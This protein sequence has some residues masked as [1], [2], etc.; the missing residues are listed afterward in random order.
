MVKAVLAAVL[1]LLQDVG[2]FSGFEQN[3]LLAICKCLEAWNW[4]NLGSNTIDAQW[5]QINCTVVADHG[6]SVPGYMPGLLYHV[7]LRRHNILG[8][9]IT[10]AD[11]MIEYLMETFTYAQENEIA[12]EN[13]KWISIM[14]WFKYAAA[15]IVLTTT[16]DQLA[17]NVRTWSSFA[18][19][20][21]VTVGSRSIMWATSDIPL[22]LDWIQT[23]Y[24]VMFNNAAAVSSPSGY[25]TLHQLDKFMH[26]P[27]NR[28]YSRNYTDTINKLSCLP[29]DCLIHQHL[30]PHIRNLQEFD[31]F[32]S[33]DTINRLGNRE[34][35]DA[36]KANSGSPGLKEWAKMIWAATVQEMHHIGKKQ[37]IEMTIIL[38]AW[39]VTEEICS[40]AS[41]DSFLVE[42]YKGLLV[43]TRYYDGK[44]IKVAEAMCPLMIYWLP[45][46]IQQLSEV[47]QPDLQRSMDIFSNYYNRRP[48]TLTESWN[49][50]YGTLEE[51]PAGKSLLLC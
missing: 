34:F 27:D 3:A 4:S 46:V 31:E 2:H 48:L 26:H 20:R 14:Q 28:K 8:K 47:Q 19:A 12:Q 7:L 50:V 33:V 11:M 23:F 38:L 6:V 24:S 9:H 29:N 15:D 16:S 41:D 30:I 32:I 49:L 45:M 40:A 51:N 13:E 1:L 18:L 44:S 21:R 35:L 37:G 17:D 43:S 10:A 42:I 36:I 25:E 22:G 5:R 39:T